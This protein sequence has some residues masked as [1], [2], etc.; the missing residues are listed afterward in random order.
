MRRSLWNKTWSDCVLTSRGMKREIEMLKIPNSIPVKTRL[1]LSAW[2]VAA[3]LTLF[4]VMSSLLHLS[5]VDHPANAQVEESQA[6]MLSKQVLAA[7][8]GFMANIR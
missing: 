7:A 1:P 2:A 8:S 4:S 3:L 6:G 5:P